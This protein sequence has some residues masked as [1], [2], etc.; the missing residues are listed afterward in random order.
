MPASL[1]NLSDAVLLTPAVV[2]VVMAREVISVDNFRLY[3]VSEEYT[4]S[5]FMIDMMVLAVFC[6]VTWYSSVRIRYNAMT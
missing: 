3:D 1:C 6:S 5:V 4:A 2:K